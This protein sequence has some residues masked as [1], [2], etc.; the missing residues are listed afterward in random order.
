VISAGFAEIGAEGRARQERLLELVRSHGARMIGPNCLG[1]SSAATRL[2]ATFAPRAFPAGSIGFS[3]QSGALGL[4]VL[5]RGEE[6]ELG[7]SA[8]VSIGNKAD[9]SSNDLLEWWGE[10][11]STELVMLYLES[12]GNPRAF[13]RIARRVARTKPVLAMKS[14]TTR[15]GVK[16]ASSH[17][18][19]PSTANP[20]D[21]LGS[22]NAKSFADVL[23]IVLADPG[24][25]AVIVLFV[26]TVGIVEED[27]GAAISRAAAGAGAKPVLCTFLS[28]KGAPASLR[29]AAHVPW[30]AYP[31]AAARALG[32]AVERGDWLSRPA[33][34][35]PML[36]VD[37]EA[38]EAI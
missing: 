27:V 26:P 10:D 21:M 31:E 36:T 8:F 24:V 28:A 2:N 18:A 16:A 6:R 13:A 9:V 32:R 14:G 33:G 12:F 20:V 5:E 15:A 35:L 7:L 29:S 17:T 22:A 1:I 38:A 19:A 23:R 4:A 34:T 11:E 25:D 30:F 37:R 3:S